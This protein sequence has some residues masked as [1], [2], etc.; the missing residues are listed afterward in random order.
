MS[1]GDDFVGVDCLS[2]PRGKY[3]SN[4][5]RTDSL[6][7][8]SWVAALFVSVA[9]IVCA[10]MGVAIDTNSKVNKLSANLTAEAGASAVANAGAL[11]DVIIDSACSRLTPPQRC[12][13]CSDLS[14]CERGACHCEIL[15]P[16][17]GDLRTHTCVSITVACAPSA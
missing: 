2:H 12:G 6:L 5:P 14:G 3:A 10:T 13:V 16:Q 17:P 11:V 9:I 15:S 1:R 8:G 7:H 4:A